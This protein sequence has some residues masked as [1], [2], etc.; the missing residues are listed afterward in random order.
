MRHFKDWS[1]TTRLFAL[2]IGASAIALA[3]SCTFFL[4]DNIRS[5]RSEKAQQLETIADMLEYHCGIVIQEGTDEALELLGTLRNTPS[6]KYA[7]LLD[8]NGDVVAEHVAPGASLPPH[9]RELQKKAH[10]KDEQS[11]YVN[12][13][14]YEIFQPVIEDGERI[15]TLYLR[16]ETGIIERQTYLAAQVT[17]F[18]AIISLGAALAFTWVMQRSISKPILDLADTAQLISERKDYSLRAK[19]TTGRNELAVLNRAFNEMLNEVQTAHERLKGTYD[20]LEV[21]IDQR[22]VQ[23]RDEVCRHEVTREELVQAKELAEAA[24]RAKSEFLANM[25]HEI[26]TPMTAILGFT[27]LLR[28]GA[29]DDDKE[30][31]REQLNL[32]YKSSQHLLELINDILDLSKVEAGEHEPQPVDCSAHEIVSDV[33]AVQQV[34]AMQKNLY[35]NYEWSTPI[36]KTIHTDPSQFRQILI[37]LVGN[38]LKFTKSGGVTVTVGMVDRNGK[39]LLAVRVTDTGIGI[40]EHKLQR[41]F[42][43]FV[44]A[45]TSVTR[46]F[47][48]TGLGLSI[49]RRIAKL[50]GGR[51]TV[52][53]KPGKGSTFTVMI[54][55]GNLDGIERLTEMPDNQTQVTARPEESDGEPEVLVDEVQA[56]E[57]LSASAPKHDLHDVKVL[58]V[59]DGEINRKLLGLILERA[60]ADTITAE[61]GQEGVQRAQKES[62]DVI[63]M[64]M[65][66]PVMDGYSATTKIRQLEIDIPVIAL[67]A[68]AMVG[69]ATQ[70]SKAGCDEYLSKP[71]EEDTLCRTIR[72]VVDA[73]RKKSPPSPISQSVETS[74]VTD[75]IFSQTAEHDMTEEQCEHLEVKLDAISATTEA[76]I[77]SSLPMDDPDFR[78]VVVDFVI[79]LNTWIDDLKKAM[80]KRDLEQLQMLSHCIKGSAGMAGFDDFTIPAADLNKAVHEERWEV[81]REKVNEVAEL[82]SRVKPPEVKS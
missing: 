26:R 31:Q 35:L 66:M 81:I 42:E 75:E 28:K 45:D 48:G 34:S 77:Y 18:V 22:T 55:P 73:Y 44:Q 52:K 30:A 16:A 74:V 9:V 72:R 37:N 13:S 54:N 49:C 50:L 51:L 33:I 58:L 38:A 24:N 11:H 67:T 82:G 56:S 40:P 2:T 6:V 62:F 19:K 8:K 17:F 23:L 78:Q 43:P 20:D 41:I 7:C 12:S 61:N 57:M 32:I 14:R 79:Q 21:R 46:Q 25:S 3:L 64:D 60:G 53:S 15:G 70:C 10:S 65:Q 71:V 1:I 4:V 47:G 80:V 63:L 59:E 68:H 5:F 29:Y 76:P 69:D 36:P 27:D 39:E